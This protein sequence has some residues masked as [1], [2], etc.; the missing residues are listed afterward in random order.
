MAQEGDDMVLAPS[1][2]GEK[3]DFPGEGVRPKRPRF[4]HWGSS[5]SNWVEGWRPKEKWV[6]GY[7][8]TVDWRVDGWGR[9]L[10]IGP[11][12]RYFDWFVHGGEFR[13]TPVPLKCI[14][15][16]NIDDEDLCQLLRA[17]ELRHHYAQRG[18]WSDCPFTEAEMVL[19]RASI[20]LASQ[21]ALDELGV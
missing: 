18:I 17:L 2:L 4:I 11:Y 6:F 19:Y 5:S 21:R 7:G 13:R 1:D 8:L 10:L 16:P 20:V 9:P 12:R 14:E 3:G 15:F